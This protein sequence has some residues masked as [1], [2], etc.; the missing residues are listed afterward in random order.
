[1]GQPRATL[2]YS[3]IH[4]KFKWQ[5][6]KLQD[7]HRV[8][9]TASQRN[10]LQCR[11]GIVYSLAT[12]SINAATPISVGT[13]SWLDK[14]HES[15]QILVIPASSSRRSLAVSVLA[16]LMSSEFDSFRSSTRPRSAFRSSETDVALRLPMNMRPPG[17]SCSE[18][19][20]TS[21]SKRYLMSSNA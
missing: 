1:M 4:R 18:Q 19:R 17:A 2:R 7:S 15:H 3:I 9:S 8:T 14:V 12:T 13:F 5:A 21:F 11:Y 20:M 10:L 6:C 16:F